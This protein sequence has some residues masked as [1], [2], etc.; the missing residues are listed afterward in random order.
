MSSTKY[1]SSSSNEGIEPVSDEEM[2]IQEHRLVKN[3]RERLSKARERDSTDS[4]NKKTRNSE[5]PKS[6]VFVPPQSTINTI[7]ESNDPADFIDALF[8][9]PST[10]RQ[11][12][13]SPTTDSHIKIAT[14][15]SV[16]PW[17][18]GTASLDSISIYK[19]DATVH[20]GHMMIYMSAISRFICTHCI[21]TVEKK[22]KDEHIERCFFRSPP[23][24]THYCHVCM[25]KNTPQSASEHFNSPKHINRMHF[26]RSIKDQ[27]RYYVDA[28]GASHLPT[29][30]TGRNTDAFSFPLHYWATRYGLAQANAAPFRISSSKRLYKL[31]STLISNKDNGSD[32]IGSNLAQKS[33]IIKCFNFFKAE[34]NFGKKLCYPPP[35]F[36]DDFVNV[37]NC[38][39]ALQEI[40]F[41]LNER[42]D[43]TRAD[44]EAKKR[45]IE[46]LFET[47]R[48]QDVNCYIHNS[49]H[50]VEY[51]KN[52]KALIKTIDAVLSQLE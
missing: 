18:S 32:D 38:F 35:K 40:C 5:E 2:D 17:G 6:R 45:E 9:R 29:S 20:Q 26:I 39:G 33:G 19:G 34:L 11:N 36:E 12:T 4:K 30:Q 47:E 10:R 42:R 49:T 31:M 7:L 44:K 43:T 21:S 1:L 14:V 15:I 13:L 24:L 37:Q 50:P 52:P 51:Y 46:K 16:T 28:Y 22:N 23:D 27:D 3:I 48:K 8:S 41:E 25:T